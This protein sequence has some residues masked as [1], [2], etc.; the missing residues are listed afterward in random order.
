LASSS[1]LIDARSELVA[2]LQIF[3]RK[4]A[5]RAFLLKVGV[6]PLGEVIVFAFNPGLY[7]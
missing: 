4:P 6:Q 1:G 5:A 2:D 7:S 3:G